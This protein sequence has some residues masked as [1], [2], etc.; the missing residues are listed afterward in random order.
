VGLLVVVMLLE[1]FVLQFGVPLEDLKF[2]LLVG[3]VGGVAERLFDVQ[4]PQFDYVQ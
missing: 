3:F 1:V 2:L 4:D